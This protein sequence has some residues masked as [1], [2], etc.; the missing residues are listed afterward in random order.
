MDDDFAEQMYTAVVEE[1]PLWELPRGVTDLLPGGAVTH[2][3]WDPAECGAAITCWL[4]RGWVELYSPGPLRAGR[5][6]RGTFCV[7][8][9]DD[10]RRLLREPARWLV[11]TPDGSVCLSRTDAGTAVD[12][13]EWIAS[14]GHG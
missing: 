2:G 10:A 9:E 5:Q 8:A 3:P 14:L 6:E 13:E 12:A 11:E 7:L 1:S 4:D